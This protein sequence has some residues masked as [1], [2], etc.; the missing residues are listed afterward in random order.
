MSRW[1]VHSKSSRV[2]FFLPSILV[3]SAEKYRTVEFEW[4]VVFSGVRI[5][6][7]AEVVVFGFT[8][9]PLSWK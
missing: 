5:L 9:T 1:K 2:Y 6:F 7:M 4:Y 3:G 8:V